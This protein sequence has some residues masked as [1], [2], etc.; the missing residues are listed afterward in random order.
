MQINRIEVVPQLPKLLRVAAYARVSD[1][2]D[3]M[4]HSLA[5]Q[6]DYY[7]DMI[8]KNPDWTFCGVFVTSVD[9]YERVKTG[10]PASAVGV[11]SREY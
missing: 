2:K 5:A 4:L 8:G 6:V 1:G 11:P 3:A 10:F 7:T 9:G